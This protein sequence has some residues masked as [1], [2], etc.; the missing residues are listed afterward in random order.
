MIK[1]NF[2]INRSIRLDKYLQD[3]F[4]N[5]GN[6]VLQKAIRNKDILVNHLKPDLKQY[7]MEGDNLLMSDFIIK[8]LS[9]KIKAEPVKNVTKQ[10][11]ERF[12]NYVIYNDEYIFAINKPSGLAVQ[13][14]SKIEKCV[15]DYLRGS[16]KLVHRLDKDTS[17]ALV[18]AKNR[19]NAEIL[20]DFFKNK[21][22]HLDKIYIAI[23]IGH[24]AKSEG[25]IN[26]PLLKKLE[27][28]VEKVYA[29]SEGK[30]AITKYK[31]LKYS[32][33]Y[34]LSLVEVRILTGRTHQIR[35]HLKEIGHP[36]LGDGKY[37]GKNVYVEG[38][39]ASK[40]FLHSLRLVIKNFHDRDTNIKAEKPIYFKRAERKLDEKE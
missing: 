20:T 13:G 17:G 23:A 33:K 22:E 6:A 11:E 21:N 34:N 7:L 4:S 31:V 27:G 16:E 5:T 39:V 25:E 19:E 1:K 40:M 29:T 30:D 18:I 2:I 36:I 32:E 9:N 37:G 8:I 28:G 12:N 24:F 14:G 26:I 10:D 38:F 35:V 15:A 3:N